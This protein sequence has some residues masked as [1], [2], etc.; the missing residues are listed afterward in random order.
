MKIPVPRP[1]LVIR[2]SFLWSHEAQKGAVE[3]SK[4]RPCAIVVAV[5]RG[6]GD[7]IRVVVSPI[8]HTPPADTSASIKIPPEVSQAIGLDGQEQWLR[9]D[10]LNSFS[11]PG[12][13]LRSVP[14]KD[15]IEYGSLP[16]HIYQQ[17]KSSILLRQRSQRSQRPINRD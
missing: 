13:D 11:W 17:L 3:A 12:F 1:G 15:D 2:Y 7:N 6:D 10:E 14:G 8:T 4:E 9:L 16:E 5:R